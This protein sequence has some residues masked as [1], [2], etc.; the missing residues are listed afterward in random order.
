MTVIEQISAPKNE[1]RHA[2][3]LIDGKR[4]ESA[5]GHTIAVENPANR[6]TIGL[7][8]RGGAEDVDRAVQAAA[9]AYPAWSRT[10]PSV[11]GRILMQ[12]GDALEARGEEIARLIALETGNALRPQARPEGH[13]VATTFRSF[14]GLG[15]ELKG[16]VVPVGEQFLS[17]SRR[18]PY[19]VVGAI[20]PWNA[21]VGLAALKIAPALCTGNTLV[22]KAAEDAPLAVL[23]VA[24]NLPAVPAPRRTQR[25]DWPRRGMWCAASRTSAG[26]QAL[27]HR[28]DRSRQV[29]DAR[30][31]GANCACLA[32]IG[33]QEPVHRLS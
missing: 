17:Y 21:P 8:P 7:V 23:L 3:M 6:R 30:G 28:V 26:T 12:I 9:R 33:R 5:S 13:G 19:G 20:I 15:G 16:E 4:V 25:A 2:L 18:E 1:L 31:G 11:R 29:G 14:G 27:L 32:G 22:L 24:E 10:N